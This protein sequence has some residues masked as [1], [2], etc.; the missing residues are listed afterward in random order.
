MSTFLV[1]QCSVLWAFVTH[2]QDAI[3]EVNKVYDATVKE[4][5]GPS[6][7]RRTSD[8]LAFVE[9]VQSRISVV[10]AASCAQ[11]STWMLATSCVT[12]V[13]VPIAFLK[14]V[15]EL[16]PVTN[17][18]WQVIIGLDSLSNAGAAVFCVGRVS[19]EVDGEATLAAGWGASAVA[20]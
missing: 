16:G 19:T 6:R 5:M 8:L 11:I 7:P 1:F 2:A 20:T 12:T 14:L 15:L 13:L 4:S 9:V 17:W 10:S 3:Q 18:V